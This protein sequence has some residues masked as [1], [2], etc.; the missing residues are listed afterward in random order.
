MAAIAIMSIVVLM[1]LILGLYLVLDSN[2]AESTVVFFK[3]LKKMCSRRQVELANAPVLSIREERSGKYYNVTVDRKVFRIGSG[4]KNDLVIPSSTVEEKHAVIYKQQKK[5]RVYYELV[6]YARSNPVE[7]YIKAKD[8]YGYLRYKAG[9]ELED[10]EAFYIG[11]T[12]VIFSI[13]KIVHRASR[14]ERVPND[15]NGNTRRV[16]TR[17]LSRTNIRR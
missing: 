3:K 16:V 15:L 12:K 6:N 10:D 14:T 11:E 2:L 5:D 1:V 8:C 4:K 9:V 7:H 17:I 13:P